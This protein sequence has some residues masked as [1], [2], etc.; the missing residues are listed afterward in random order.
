VRKCR[1]QV[2]LVFFGAEV[3]VSGHFGDLGAEVQVLG[4]FVYLGAEVQVSGH[5]G[6]L[7]A[8]VQV[9][10]QFVYLGAEVQVSGHFVYLGEKG[11]QSLVFGVNLLHTSALSVKCDNKCN[12]FRQAV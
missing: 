3:Q 8:E 10:G 4:H 2:I 12:L 1:L 5:F 11:V 9:L 7:G 6:E